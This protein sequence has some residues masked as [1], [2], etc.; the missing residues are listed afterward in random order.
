MWAEKFVSMNQ[1]FVSMN[2]SVHEVCGQRKADLCIEFKSEKNKGISNID[3]GYLT[4]HKSE[5]KV[6]S[7]SNQVYLTTSHE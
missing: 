3:H 6:L 2:Q 4:N 7:N 1:S 5:H